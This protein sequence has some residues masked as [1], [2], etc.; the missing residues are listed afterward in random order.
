MQ[1]DR[2]AEGF[3]IITTFLWGGTFTAIK[4]ALADVSPLMLVGVRFVAAAVL[5]WPLL[6][7][8]G[9]NTRDD[10][11]ITGRSGVLRHF[12]PAAWLWGFVLGLGMLL[13]YAGQTIGLKYTSVARSGF[14]TYSF[15][16][17]VPFFQFLFLKKKPGRGNLLGLLVVFWGFSFVIDPATGPL[18]LRELGPW[19]MLDMIDNLAAGGLNAGD[20]FSLVGAVGYAAYV[21]LL[22]RATRVV[23]PGAVT[24]LQ[25]LF[26]GIFAMV[27]SPLVEEPRFEMSVALVASL[28]YLIVFGS[29]VALALMN[30][31]QR[32]LTPL[33]AVLIY[34]TEPVFAALIAWMVFDTGM[35]Y[36]E[37]AGAVL[38]LSGIIVS[39]LWNISVSR[40]VGHRARRSTET[41]SP[42]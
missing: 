33:R 22:D 7:R 6:L 28:L 23:H 24:V 40:R 25:M 14:I 42:G 18:T 30:W 38:I 5:A 26:C 29:I 9:R 17:M 36:R 13:G 4:F 19:R 32:R 20:L 15:A 12:T 31:F 21:V 8:S 3:L 39:D 41:G 2:G 35:S 1:R 34:S 11:S 16:L 37:I 10:A 27:L